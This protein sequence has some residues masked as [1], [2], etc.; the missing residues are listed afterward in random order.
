MKKILIIITVMITALIMTGCPNIF[1]GKANNYHPT[2]DDSIPEGYGSVQVS[3]VQGGARTA[4]PAMVWNDFRLDYTFYK[5]GSTTGS[6]KTPVT[7]FNEGTIEFLLETGTYKLEVKA[8]Y[9]GGGGAEVL[10]A[11]G[12]ATFTITSGPNSPIPI[13]LKHVTPNGTGTLQ[14][15]L[16]LETSLNVNDV[17]IDTFTLT[18]LFASNPPNDIIFNSVRCQEKN[19][20]NF[21]VDSYLNEN[22]SVPSGYYLLHLLLR[23][24][25]VLPPDS[26]A[27]RTV[28]VHIYENQVT[29][30]KLELASDDFVSNVVLNKEDDGEGSLR[31]ALNN[32]PS[33]AIIRVMLPPGSKIELRSQLTIPGPGK[34]VVIEG[35]GVILTRNNNYFS[36]G[37][38]L[39]IDDPS[40][41]ITI[42]RIHFKGG[43]NPTAEGG[44]IANTGN[45]T[46]ESCIFSENTAQTAGAIYNNA[47]G[48]LTVKG[49][50][51]YKNMA[52]IRG[53]AILNEDS[54]T[55]MGNLFYENT[56]GQYPVLYNDVPSI[57]NTYN[58]VDAP[59]GD[60]E[61][62]QCGWEQNTITGKADKYITEV[63]FSPVRFRLFP[64]SAKNL[65]KISFSDNYPTVDFYGK[66][67]KSGKAYPGAVQ[68]FVEGTGFYLD[69][70]PNDVSGFSNTSSPDGLYDAGHSI[71]LQMIGY[72]TNKYWV[73]NGVVMQSSPAYT[74]LST[75]VSR[76]A[77]VEVV[78][79]EVVNNWTT[80]KT[81]VSNR[82]K[83]IR[84]SANIDADST[85][86]I[87][88]DLNITL[89]AM[90][91]M[92]YSINW[93]SG[94]TDPF[95][96]I[97]TGS[98]LTLG[99]KVKLSSSGQINMTGTVGPNDAF[100]K[101]DGGTLVMN[102]NVTLEDNQSTAYRTGGAV[103]I[104]S[105]TFIMNKGTIKNNYATNGGGVYVNSGFFI[106]NGGSINNNNADSAT[107]GFG[108]G[109]G[110][111]VGNSGTF[112]KNGGTIENN[113]AST[114]EGDQ[115]YVTK[116]DTTTHPPDNRA[117]GYI[118]AAI[119][120]STQF[121]TSKSTSGVP[122]IS[123]Q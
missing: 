61:A 103:E 71:D 7:D 77:K 58:V 30:L 10:A 36:S 113:G 39:R 6:S 59:F 49:C 120:A 25:E 11:T 75:G 4:I 50:T 9:I 47:S 87:D 93:Q 53:G 12:N 115:V 118:N 98:S 51:F 74:V 18:P 62:Y 111:Y 14:I 44:A 108:Y 37:S 56:A 72:S 33:N 60:S 16:K 23:R 26:F 97:N 54:I 35:N 91:N 13:T 70:N 52:T 123:I 95:F 76:Y 67:I 31:Y 27:S 38:L 45:L 112:I 122:W 90:D 41:Q 8:Y 42:K 116:V 80:V 22:F 32:A 29:S 106:M 19:N 46:V 78:F 100:I 69:V 79:A 15:P 105:G 89:V 3:L 40:H 28:V 66:P 43:N 2:P 94:F 57:N 117:G 24:L 114:S 101:V 20:T 96:T 119:D 17:K 83:I 85:I 84:I 88:N 109:G 21:I 73:E 63:P 86:T 107:P 110:V 81:T 102:D 48:T 92:D 65:P 1:S 5:N 34:N 121:D 82:N 64:E 104:T 68:D 99:A 55:L